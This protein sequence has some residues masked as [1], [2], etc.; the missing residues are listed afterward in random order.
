MLLLAGR[1][2]AQMPTVWIDALATSARPPSGLVDRSVGVYGML[3]GR[4]HWTLPSVNLDASGYLGL[5]ARQYD[6]R[7]GL[8]S[9][10][11]S[12]YRSFGALRSN[13]ELELFGL[14][15]ADPLSYTALSATGRPTFTYRVG[16]LEIAGTGELSVGTWGARTRTQ[17]VDPELPPDP[18]TASTVERSGRLRVLGFRGTLAAPL[19]RGSVTLGGVLA[20]ARNGTRDGTYRGGSLSLL[21]V[22]DRWDVMLEGQVLNGPDKT[23]AGAILR[24]GRFVDD[25]VYVSAEVGRR[26]SDYNLGTPG[27]T[28]ATLGVSWQ[29][30]TTRPLGRPRPLVV[31]VG[32]RDEKGTHVEFHLPK[33]AASSVALVGSFTEW[34]PR[35]MTRAADGWT[36]ALVL[37]E[38]SHQFAFLLDGLRWHLP[39]GS[40]GI[41]EDGYGRRNA[42][43][44]IG[45]M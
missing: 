18:V 26:V 39:E 35:A 9:L 15:Y 10:S 38:G 40:P 30:G 22:R 2:A 29:P 42:T 11:A 32:M 5:G 12:R 8:V 27:H 20:N 28:G 21:Q 13:V 45:T 17:P 23:E 44:V 3:G 16:G 7:W 41:I 1:A 4:A 37:P 43:V 25:R 36:L 14:H 24:A 31:R 6:G 19:Y 34:Q 33:T